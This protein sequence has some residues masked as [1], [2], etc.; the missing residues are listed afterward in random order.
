MAV[1]TI[2]VGRLT[3]Y[4][5]NKITLIIQMLHVVTIYELQFHLSDCKC[6]GSFENKILEVY[7]LKR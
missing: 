7:Q 6:I 3:H 2:W 4:Y 1:Y 5:N